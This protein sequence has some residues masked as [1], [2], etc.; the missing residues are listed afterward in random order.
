MY[1][2][3][4]LYIYIYIYIYIILYIFKYI[5]LYIIIL[6]DIVIYSVYIIFY[7]SS[8]LTQALQAM[9]SSKPHKY[10][11]MERLWKDYIYICMSILVHVMPC[12]N[13]YTM[14]R[15]IMYIAIHTKASTPNIICISPPNWWIMK[16]LYEDYDDCWWIMLR[17][18]KGCG[19]LQ[20]GLC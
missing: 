19:R 8:K 15:Y 5:K 6:Y 11:I 3:F 12:I 14:C 9:L 18:W 7:T 13:I 17:F 10:R 16:G 4:K 20:Q 1:I 2:L